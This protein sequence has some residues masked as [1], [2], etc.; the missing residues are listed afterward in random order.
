M[1]DLVT[2]F[3]LIFLVAGF[4]SRWYLTGK[5]RK[6]VTNA[7]VEMVE[8]IGWQILP[9]RRLPNGVPSTIVIGGDIA[10]RQVEVVA[11]A[12]YIQRWQAP[13]EYM[14][15]IVAL[16]NPTGLVVQAGL[17][18]KLLRNSDKRYRS[19]KIVKSGDR[20]FDDA[21]RIRG[22]PED[23]LGK[24]LAANDVQSAIRKLYPGSS[25]LA[26]HPRLQVEGDRLAA[27]IPMVYSSEE[28]VQKAIEQTCA[29]ANSIEQQLET[30]L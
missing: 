30:K 21:H 14:D 19:L 24:I 26:N 16:N 5:K 18:E 13:I 10:G 25:P 8:K 28:G 9:E 12:D 2:A 15:I 22:L 17:H 6:T 29:L 7:W 23:L 11:N 20:L 1:D 3:L 4:S 27:R